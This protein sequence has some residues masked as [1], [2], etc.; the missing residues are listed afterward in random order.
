MVSDY[1]RGTFLPGVIVETGLVRGVWGGDGG[2]IF[3]RALDDTAWDSRRGETDVENIGQ[4]GRAA[5]VLHGF[6]QREARGATQ[7]RDAQDERQRGRRCGSNFCTGMS[8]T[9]WSL[10]RREIPPT[11]GDPNMTLWSPGL[12]L[13]EGT[14]PPQSAPGE[15]SERGGS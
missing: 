14:L 2:G 13:I 9:L 12:H 10:W 5:D 15:R 6:R 1:G 7:Y 8:W 4:G 11:H 3:G